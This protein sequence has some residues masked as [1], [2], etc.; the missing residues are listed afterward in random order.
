MTKDDREIVSALRAALAD[1]VGKQRFDLWFGAGTR[2]DYD[3]QTLRIGAPNLFFLE[4][5]RA[6]FRRH[7]EGSCNEVLGKCPALEFQLDASS[8]EN[9]EDLMRSTSMKQ[10]APTNGTLKHAQPGPRLAA[11]EL[12]T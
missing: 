10:S 2:L 4:W 11:P 5:I 3:G 6:N 8:T 7:I 12:N 1:K 9:D